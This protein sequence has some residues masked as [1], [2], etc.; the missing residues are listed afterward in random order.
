[1][2]DEKPMDKDIAD[3]LIQQL[4]WFGSKEISESDRNDVIAALHWFANLRLEEAA[5]LAEVANSHIAEKIRE[6]KSN[7]YHVTS[8]TES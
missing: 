1:M 4:E 2:I 8:G 5:K 3:H 6:L 7:R